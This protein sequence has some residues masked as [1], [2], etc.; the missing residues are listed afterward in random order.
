[1]GICCLF[2]KVIGTALL[3]L[4]FAAP[5]GAQVEDQLSAYTG[6][7]A[8]GY[9]DPL[10]G[11]IGGSMN[12]GLFRSA[13]IPKEGFTFSLEFPIIG[14]FF[15]D[16][17]K[18][19]TAT[20]EGGFSPTQTADAPTVVG[21][22]EAVTVSGDGGT[23]YAFPGGF[24]VGSF[25]FTC[26]QLRV[27]A[28][29]GTEAMIRFIAFK[30]GDNELGDLSLFGLGFR[31]NFSQYMGPEPPVDIAAS[32]FWQSFKLGENEDGSDLFETSAY[33]IGVQGSRH[34]PPFL[35]PYTGLYYNSYT[36]DI[37]YV[38]E[39][40]GDEESIDLSF[41]DGYVQWT[42][43]LELNASVL[44]LFVEYNVSSHSSFAFGLGFGI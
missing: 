25:A 11:A 39:S 10:I 43:G 33:S 13:Y 8:E 26:P 4:L 31:H 19:F 5:L 16:D 9:L 37:S 38:S 12:A 22:T 7:N 17:D 6:D 20:T 41:D 2:R 23:T 34:F 15:G 27:G 21:P 44:D 29:F 40:E 28:V 14:F 3:V 32:F 30:V 1:M 35:T 18:T 42:I 24:D 36:T